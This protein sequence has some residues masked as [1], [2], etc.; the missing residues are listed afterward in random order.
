MNVSEHEFWEIGMS[1]PSETN[2]YFDAYN[3][4][5][6]YHN[7]GMLQFVLFFKQMLTY[8]TVFIPN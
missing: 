8:V 4:F 5:N 2:K 7:I 6:F 3:F 1:T